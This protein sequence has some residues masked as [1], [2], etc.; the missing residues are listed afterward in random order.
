MYAKH[1]EFLSRLLYQKLDKFTD[2]I[3]LF[4]AKSRDEIWTTKT[5]QILS[6]TATG[7]R[8]VIAG[9]YSERDG[10][11]YPDPH[12]HMSVGEGIVDLDSIRI[13]TVGGEI[14]MGK[15]AAWNGGFCLQFLFEIIDQKESKQLENRNVLAI[16]A[17]SQIV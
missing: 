5:Y 13:Y 12:Y 7:S 10:N 3:E 17:Q 15:P 1:E 8:T 16:A 4:L 14:A 9:Y 11:Q 6:I 2:G